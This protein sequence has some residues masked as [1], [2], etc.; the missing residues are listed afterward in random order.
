MRVP[1][2]GTLVGRPSGSGWTT[3]RFMKPLELP[4]RTIRP[5]SSPVR[6]SIAQRPRMSGV[7]FTATGCGVFRHGAGRRDQ[8]PIHASTA[9]INNIPRTSRR[10]VD[11]EGLGFR[12]ERIGHPCRFEIRPRSVRAPL[13]RVSSAGSPPVHPFTRSPVHPFTRSP[14]HPLTPY[15]PAAP[16]E[17][18]PSPPAARSRPAECGCRRSRRPAPRRPPAGAPG[19]TRRCSPPPRPAASPRGR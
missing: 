11:G 16:P 2:M 19:G 4:M 18:P 17:S 6:R 15:P 14:V 13:R 1:L 7:E 5:H 3:Y 8:N 9:R 10:R 12:R